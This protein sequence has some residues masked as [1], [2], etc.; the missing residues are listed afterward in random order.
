M[1]RERLA[2]ELLQ[3]AEE[4]EQLDGGTPVNW[5]DWIVTGARERVTIP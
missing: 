1:A 5:F 2:R 3:V 4:L